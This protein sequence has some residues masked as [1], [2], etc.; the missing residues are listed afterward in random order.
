MLHTCEMQGTDR[1]LPMYCSTSF[2]LD[3]SQPEL[4]QHM[5]YPNFL[6]HSELQEALRSS[7]AAAQAVDGS[8]S[9]AA[10]QTVAAAAAGMAVLPLRASQADVLASLAAFAGKSVISLRGLAPGWLTGLSDQ[11]DVTFVT[12]LMYNLT[13][14]SGWC[15]LMTESSAT[16][17]GQ[18]MQHAFVGYQGAH[19][20]TTAALRQQLTSASL[21]GSSSSSSGGGIYDAKA[22][23]DLLWKPADALF[24]RPAWCDE[25]AGYL[26]PYNL[27]LSR[28]RQHPC[29]Y[30]AGVQ[31]SWQLQQ[32]LAGALAEV[33]QLRAGVAAAGN[34][35]ASAMAVS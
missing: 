3:V 12:D 26:K 8:S 19:L 31:Y 9:L 33:H 28:L 15:C 11:D 32:G 7:S 5:R 24:T 18:D 17:A 30:L 2:Y 16:A 29:S 14:T 21:Y 1:R 27:N 20:I 34:A 13:A 6:A 4:Q 35:G 22:V 10:M 23:A 25:S